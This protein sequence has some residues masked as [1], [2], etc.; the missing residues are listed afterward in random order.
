MPPTIAKIAMTAPMA[1]HFPLI[2]VSISNC[3]FNRYMIIGKIF[4]DSTAQLAHMD[5]K[6]HEVLGFGLFG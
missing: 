4:Q 6:A 5:S 1:I 2:C 3:G